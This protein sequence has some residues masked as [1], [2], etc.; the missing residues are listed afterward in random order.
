MDTTT[1]ETE[2]TAEQILLVQASWEQLEPLAA[3]LG[4]V[5][6][7]R[8]FEQLPETKPLF[9]RDTRE[10]GIAL[11]SMLGVA[12]NML[13]RLESIDPLMKTLGQR[14]EIRGVKPEMV[15]PFREVL[16]DTLSVVLGKAC[17]E[18]V[19]DAWEAMFNTLARKMGMLA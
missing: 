3:K 1:H 9:S 17:T 6:Y 15:E 11:M 7:N 8:L 10:Q 18:Q 16:L 12:V 5:F 13:D 4:E 19:R 2:L 14:H